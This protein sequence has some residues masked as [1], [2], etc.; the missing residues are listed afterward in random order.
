MREEHFRSP[1]STGAPTGSQFDLDVVGVA[2]D[3]ERTPAVSLDVLN[4]RVRHAQGIKAVRPRFK[5]A[6][7]AHT[8]GDMVESDPPLVKGRSI[9]PEPNQNLTAET[10]TEDAAA[11]LAEAGEVLGELE[12]L[13]RRINRTDAAT[14]VE[15]GGTSTDALAR[16]DAQVAMWRSVHVRV[17][18]SAQA[19]SRSR[20][21]SGGAA[22]RQRCSP[23]TVKDDWVAE[24]SL[25]HLHSR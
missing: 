10:P 18:E 7:V 16:R 4:A 2:Q 23:P 20:A 6:E 21:R 3:D 15:D 12:L 5:S 25:Q 9:A 22:I 8:K 13:I 14:P 17:F 11:L 19:F 1:T 24:P